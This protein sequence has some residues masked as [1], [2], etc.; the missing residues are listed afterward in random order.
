MTRTTYLMMLALSGFLLTAS[1]AF[2]AELT[3]DDLLYIKKNTIYLPR[4]LSPSQI[5]GL[6]NVINDPKTK[7]DPK[8]RLESVNHYLDV[9]MATILACTVNPNHPD[10]RKCPDCGK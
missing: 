7:T 8:T 1:L 10:C 3:A 9:A 4:H 2:A 5:T 6:H